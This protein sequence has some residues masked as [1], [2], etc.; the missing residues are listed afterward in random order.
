MPFAAF[1]KTL[2]QTLAPLLSPP[3][4][5]PYLFLLLQKLRVE[6]PTAEL[7]Q[8]KGSFGHPLGIDVLECVPASALQLHQLSIS[9]AKF[10]YP[11][12]CGITGSKAAFT[13]IWA[14]LLQREEALIAQIVCRSN[15][16]PRLVALVPHKGT[17]ED[18]SCGLLMFALAYI[19]D[20]RIPPTP[21]QPMPLSGDALAAASEFVKAMAIKFSPASFPNPLLESHYTLLHDF[22]LGVS[23]PADFQIP[24]AIVPA[25]SILAK[26]DTAA[27]QLV[28]HLYGG[29]AVA[30][31]GAKRRREDNRDVN[32]E[33]SDIVVVAEVVGQGNI[34][35]HSL[36]RLKELC[37]S[38]GLKINGTKAV[39][40]ERLTQ[41]FSQ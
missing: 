39:L 22:A 1:P 13:S 10:L 40:A 35:Q 30:D 8:L 6:F 29:K 34:M 3:P 15:A 9:S 11:S 41:R 14:E 37:K 33:L 32:E 23:R 5:I 26:A 31:L 38:A 17:D 7:G 21:T 4:S 16:P 36:D 28:G 2:K 12:S 20:I 18:D 25:P 27:A 24:D 19:D